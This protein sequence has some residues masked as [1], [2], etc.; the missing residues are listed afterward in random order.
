MK[1]L[2]LAAL[3]ISSLGAQELPIPSALRDAKT[4]YVVNKGVYPKQIEHGLKTMAEGK[5][6]T[7]VA[8]AKEADVTLTFSAQPAKQIYNWATNSTMTANSNFP[9]N[10][11]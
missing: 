7:V 11:R 10:H 6:W 4:I 2:L 3:V 1:L 9:R 8:E 5:R